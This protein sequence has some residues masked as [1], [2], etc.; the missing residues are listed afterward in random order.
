MAPAIWLAITLPP[1]ALAIR[2]PLISRLTAAASGTDRTIRGGNG[3]IAGVDQRTGTGA[4]RGRADA[5]IAVAVL[6]RT[7]RAEETAAF[8]E[9][10]VRPAVLA[11]M[12]SIWIG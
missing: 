12:N 3:G 6:Q 10:T 11:P 5:R 2:A 4:E 9:L 8:G 7:L 1:V